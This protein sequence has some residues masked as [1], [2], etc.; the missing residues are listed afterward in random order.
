MKPNVSAA[1]KAVAGGKVIFCLL[2]GKNRT[3]WLT[4]SGDALPRK[5]YDIIR[6]DGWVRLEEMPDP[7]EGATKWYRV[8]LSVEGRKVWMPE[9]TQTS[10]SSSVNS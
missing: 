6:M 9:S 2:D 1:M 4:R 3:V 7:P 8:L 5:G 10:E